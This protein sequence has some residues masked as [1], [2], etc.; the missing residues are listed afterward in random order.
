MQEVLEWLSERGYA[1]VEIVKTADESLTFSLPKEL[2][3]KDLRAVAEKLGAGA[4][5]QE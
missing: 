4:P 5:V 2:R 1:D 3:N